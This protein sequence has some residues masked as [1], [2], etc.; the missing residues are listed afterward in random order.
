M[1]DGGMY[2]ESTLLGEECIRSNLKN[3]LLINIA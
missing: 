3:V 2:T 1:V